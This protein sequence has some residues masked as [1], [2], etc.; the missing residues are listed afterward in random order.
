MEEKNI[1]NNATRLS[2]VVIY[3]MQEKKA[4]DIVIIDLRNIQNSVADYF[5]VCSGN[6]DTQV[7]AIYNSVEEQ[8]YKQLGED[9]WNTEGIQHKEW[10]LLDYVDVVVHIFKKTQRDFYALEDLWGDAVSTPIESEMSG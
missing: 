6:S 1:E 10:V 2:Q 9:P 3:G 7:D 4:M 5:V 8:V